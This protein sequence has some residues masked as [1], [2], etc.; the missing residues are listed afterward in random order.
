MKQIMAG[1]V[2]SRKLLAGALIGSIMVVCTDAWAETS[3]KKGDASLRVEYQYIRTGE[4]DSSV[5]KIDIG[6]TDSHAIVLSGDYAFND[7]WKVFASLP[8]IQKRHKGALPHDPTV[9]FV[10][11]TPPDMRVTDDGSYHGGFQDLFFG[12]QYLAL[13]G[14]LELAP[15]ISYGLPASNYPFYAHAAIGRNIWHLPVGVSLS[16]TPYFSDWYLKSDIAYVFTE[17]SLGVNVSH[18][19]IYAS[20]SYFF[21]P[22]FAP[23]AFVSI[24]HVNGGLSFPDDF[25]PESFDSEHWYYHDRTIKH[26]FVNAGVGFDWILNEKYQLSGTLFTMVKPEQV[27]TIEYAFTLGLTRYFGGSQ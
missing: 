5:G 10:N 22:R 24:K 6:N 16:Y 26:N 27:N 13:D 12:L 18:W 23:K 20:A 4:Y 2:L 21:T 3:Q 8:Y 25:P 15:F 19:L 7:R 11:Y 9:D 1:L 17:K 14:P